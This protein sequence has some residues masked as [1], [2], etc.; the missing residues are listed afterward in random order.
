MKKNYNVFY[1]FAIFQ[2]ILTLRYLFHICL[3]KLL[4]KLYY[5]CANCS[6]TFELLKTKLLHIFVENKIIF[7][8]LI[9]RRIVKIY[10][11]T[12]KGYESQTSSQVSR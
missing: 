4:M 5:Y 2:W 3:K 1:Y 6:K 10:V 7:T 11:L 8:S 9:I 12:F